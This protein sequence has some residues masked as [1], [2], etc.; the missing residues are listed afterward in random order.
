M[1]SLRIL[2]EFVYCS[3]QVVDSLTR[4]SLV[5]STSFKS[6]PYQVPPDHVLQQLH[7]CSNPLLLFYCCCIQTVTSREGDKSQIS[8]QQYHFRPLSWVLT[9][10]FTAIDIAPNNN[11]HIE[12]SI[13]HF[14]ISLIRMQ[15]SSSASNFNSSWD[16][17]LFTSTIK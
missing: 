12:R 13:Q 4:F 9:E 15:T 16:S 14:P 11:A 2:F 10:G 6:L 3:L 17:A 1:F 8:A 7:L 5:A